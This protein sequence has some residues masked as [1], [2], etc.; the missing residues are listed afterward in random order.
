MSP[1]MVPFNSVNKNR[2]ARPVT[3]DETQSLEFT[4]YQRG[5]TTDRLHT[6]HIHTMLGWSQC[7][8][9]LVDFRG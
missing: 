2:V 7:D 8:K 9:H 3:R 1:V 4:S 5:V 6:Y